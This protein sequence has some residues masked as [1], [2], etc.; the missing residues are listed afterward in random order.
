MDDPALTSQAIAELMR[1][2]PSNNGKA[3]YEP[4]ERKINPLGKPNKKFLGRTINTALWHNKRAIERTQASCQQKLQELD[5]RYERRKTNAF[6]SHNKKEESYGRRERKSRSRKKLRKR[7][8]SRSTSSESRSRSRSHKKK[9]KK[10]HSKFKRRQRRR[11]SSCSSSSEAAPPA[12]TADELTVP[13]PEYYVHSNNL[14]LAMAMAYSQTLFAHQTPANKP[15][16]PASPSSDII[17]ELMSDEETMKQE[18]ESD[19]LSIASSSEEV[20]EI[21]TIDVSS[22]DE[23]SVGDSGTDSESDA[24][25]CSSIALL[26]SGSDELAS[27]SGSDIEIIECDTEPREEQNQLPVESTQQAEPEET[28]SAPTVDLTDD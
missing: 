27:N 8:K 19:T 22:Q 2:F 5:D 28:L 12:K 14:A 17:R 26:D 16:S 4:Q 20:P 24:R 1:E 21:V 25:N 15:H 6:Y 13:R 23:Q 18:I 10:K 9:H 7:H 11:R 3:S